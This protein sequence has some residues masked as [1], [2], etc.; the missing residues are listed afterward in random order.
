M[1]VGLIHSTRLVLPWI[2]AAL[3]PLASR[4]RFLHALDEALIVEL[5]KGEG[6]TDGVLRRIASLARSLAEAGADRLVLSCSSLSPAVDELAPSLP[7]PLAKIDEAMI[8]AALRAS[9]PFVIVATNPS[10]RRPLGLIVE[11]VAA[12]LGVEPDWR[13]ELLDG[14]FSA[15]DR[16][17]TEGHDAAVA[18]A[19]ETL[20][21]TGRAILFAQISMAR[22]LPRLTEAAKAVT[23]T[24]LDY[25]EESALGERGAPTQ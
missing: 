2:E 3:R 11:R 20:A 6:V 14:A 17:D 22:V 12:R 16:G 19:C 23:K 21:A 18:S 7:I 25:I 24:S 9:I 5:A 13:Y 8:V 15:L 10:T 4:A 1:T